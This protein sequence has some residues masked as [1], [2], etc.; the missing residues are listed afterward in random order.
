[1]HTKTKN[2]LN[3]IELKSN[4]LRTLSNFMIQN[5]FIGNTTIICIH[6]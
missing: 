6:G 2:A 1:M 5:L 3:L 4:L